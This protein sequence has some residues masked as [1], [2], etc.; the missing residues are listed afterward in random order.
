[1]VGPARSN[2]H[3][4]PTTLAPSSLPSTPVSFICASA[5]PS[6]PPAVPPARHQQLVRGPCPTSPPPRHACNACSFFRPPLCP[7]CRRRPHTLAGVVCH[8]AQG[9]EAPSFIIT[10]LHAGG[11]PGRPGVAQGQAGRQGSTHTAQRWGLFLTRWARGRKPAAAA[12]HQPPVVLIKCRPHSVARPPPPAPL[13]PAAW[14][15]KS[16]VCA[17]VQRGSA[18]KSQ[19]HGLLR[20]QKKTKPAQPCGSVGG[21]GRAVHAALATPHP[22]A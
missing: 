16:C 6:P 3:P 4:L 17:C 19:G 20:R 14:W 9:C 1:M 18:Q 11:W 8:A 12:L 21:G 2:Q 15:P 22:P 10:W 7:A 13:T 5:P